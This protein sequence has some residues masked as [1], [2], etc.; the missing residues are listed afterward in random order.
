MHMIHT[1]ESAVMWR[2][3]DVSHLI[4][5]RGHGISGQRLSWIFCCLQTQILLASESVLLDAEG[6]GELLEVSF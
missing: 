5:G 3:L 2:L 4:S 6:G 1:A